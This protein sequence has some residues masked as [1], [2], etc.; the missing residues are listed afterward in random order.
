MN[1]LTFDTEEWFLEKAYFGNSSEKYQ[2]YDRYLKSILDLLD[3][4]QLK[5]TFFCVGGLA[6]QFPEIVRAISDKGHEIG[7][8]SNAHLW[9][10]TF[11]RK[12]LTEDTRI[13]IKSL[14]DVSGQKVISYRAPAFSIGEKNK[15]AIEV[16]AECGIERDTSIFPA[17]RDFGGFQSFSSNEPCLINVNNITLK[18]F[19]IQ[20]TSVAGKQ[21]AYSGGGFFRFFPLSFVKSKMN[22]NNYNM[23]YFHIGDI[24]FKP[25]VLRSKEFYESYYKEPGTLKNRVIRMIKTSLGTRH[26]FDKM[27]TLVRTL[28]FVNVKQADELIDWNIA[29]VIE[30]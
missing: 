26:A 12:G 30:L 5:A 21:V 15:W 16:L 3:E 23:V 4:Q 9:L 24:M 7:C 22:S 19:P 11:D 10:S 2:I 14:E 13:A 27:C 25:L 20:L 6:I 1:I 17:A 18:E 8:H 28:E 29:P